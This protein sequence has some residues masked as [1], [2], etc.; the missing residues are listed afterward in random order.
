MKTFAVLTM[1]GVLTTFAASPIQAHPGHGDD[2]PAPAL[3]NASPRTEAHSDLFELVA[4]VKA[5]A[6]VIYLDRFATNEPVEGASIEVGEGDTAAGRHLQADR[7]I[8]GP[9]RASRPGAHG[10][11][12]RRRGSAERQP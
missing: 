7:A 12:G 6:A 1:L 8:A 11:C 10:D 9:T 4:T 3:G 2:A 5:G